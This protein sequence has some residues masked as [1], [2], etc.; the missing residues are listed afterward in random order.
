MCVVALMMI[1]GV[2]MLAIVAMVLVGVKVVA[3]VVVVTS[4]RCDSASRHTHNQYT[5]SA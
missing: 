2:V 3:A 5:P 1:D 4:S